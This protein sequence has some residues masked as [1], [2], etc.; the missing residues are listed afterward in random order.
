MKRAIVAGNGFG[1]QDLASAINQASLGDTILISPGTYNLGGYDLNGL[2]LKGKGKHPRDVIIQGNFTIDNAN[3]EFKNLTLQSQGLIT[4]YAKNNANVQIINSIMEG[5]DAE[6]ELKSTDSTVV[7]ESST[8]VNTFIYSERTAINIDQSMIES[9]NLWENSQVTLNDSQLKYIGLGNSTLNGRGVYLEKNNYNLDIYSGPEANVHLKDIHFENFNLQIMSHYKSSVV[10]DEVKSNTGH[11]QVFK[12]GDTSVDI[13]NSEIIN[14]DNLFKR[15]VTV[16][17]SDK[18]VNFNKYDVGT[19][20]QLEPGEYNIGDYSYNVLKLKGLGNNKSQ[21]IL[22]GPISTVGGYLNLEN[23]TIASGPENNSIVVQEKGQLVLKNVTVTS[24]AIEYPLL[25][26]KNSTVDIFGLSEHIQ[27]GLKEYA[28][29]LLQSDGNICQSKLAGLYAD[30]SNVKLINNS[31]ENK[32]T[33]KNSKSV[34]QNI[35]TGSLMELDNSNIIVENISALD[36][37]TNITARNGSKFLFDEPAVSHNDL[38]LYADKESIFT[39]SLDISKDIGLYQENQAIYSSSFNKIDRQIGLDKFKKQVR[40]YIDLIKFHKQRDSQGYVTIDKN[41]NGLF[42]GNLN[43]KKEPMAKL[44]CDLLYEEKILEKN[45]FLSLSVTDFNNKTVTEKTSQR[46]NAA[47]GGMIFISLGGNVKNATILLNNFTNLIKTQGTRTVVVASGSESLIDEIF[48]DNPGFKNYY[49]NRFE[50]ENYSYSEA[51]DEGLSSLR[52]LDFQVNKDLYRSVFMK[53]IRTETDNNTDL[54]DWIANQNKL[55]IRKLASSSDDMNVIPDN[56][57]NPTN[58]NEHDNRKLNELLDE[59]DN[60][61]GLHNVK[62]MVHELVKVARVNQKLAGRISTDSSSTYHMAFTGNPGTGKTTVARI[63]AKIF[64]E[65]GF[66]PKNTVTEVA[67]P[68]LVAGYIGQ[69]EI[70]TMNAI[71]QSMGGVLFIDEAYQLSKKNDRKDFGHQA[72]ETLVT[73]L[74]NHRS[75]FIAIFAGYTDEMNDFLNENPGLRSRIPNVIE[76]DDYTPDEIGE[77]VVSQMEKDWHFDKTHLMEVTSSMYGQLPKEDQ[78]NGRWARNFSESLIDS[79]KVWLADHEDVEDAKYITNDLIDQ[80]AGISTHKKADGLN[81]LMKQLDSMIGLENV[82]KSVH[83]LVKIA[84]VNSKLNDG[85]PESQLPTYH[86]VFTG[87]PGTGKTTVARIIAKVFYELGFLPKDTVMEVSRPDLVAGYV[88]QTEEKTLNVIQKSM[89]GVLFVDE[90]YQLNGKYQNDFGHQAVETF[91]TEL[92]NHRRDFIAIF[93]GY[94]DEMNDFLDENPGLRSRIP[95]TI[96][97]DDY[98]SDQIAMIV[99]SILKENWTYESNVLRDKVIDKYDSLPIKDKSN[100]RWA[101]NFSERLVNNHK[102]WLADHLDDVDD[103]R[104]ISNDII[105]QTCEEM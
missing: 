99:D 5:L 6:A 54:G 8:F 34:M 82:K 23:L 83:S 91:V 50:L 55:L 81:D 45:S 97:F 49:P 46:S 10:I 38:I 59:L 67:R 73:E 79:Q 39:G 3:A 84:R 32:M 2:T 96:E 15:T 64:H 24:K 100:G 102:T 68:E 104:H 1:K 78:G 44:L 26:I 69:T 18:V 19:T 60:M 77:I 16:K 101:R 66:L 58:V 20:I 13:P 31:V 37:Q 35:K 47:S 40:E 95:Q 72:I 29:T 85:M 75:G 86:M 21:V 28:T 93:A 22:H 41:F 71:R 87:N 92:E 36:Q 70:K 14:W 61:I 105:E 94:T 9:M 57:L 33:Y 12:A 80:V 43:S 88:G 51:V 48:K 90:A 52:D 42:L 76:F 56:V 63:I 30:K 103:L 17:P 89:G 98:T 62:K 53:K 25:F 65:I 74:E 27:A 4:V 7:I 11:I